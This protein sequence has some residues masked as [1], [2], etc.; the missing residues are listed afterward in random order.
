MGLLS[1]QTPEAAASTGNFIDFS[2]HETLN[3]KTFITFYLLI[4][5]L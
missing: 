4:I 5:V 3:N 2:R 1:V